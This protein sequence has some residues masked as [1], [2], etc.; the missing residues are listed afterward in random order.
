MTGVAGSVSIFLT[1]G[2]ASEGEQKHGLVLV[3]ASAKH[4]SE[5][6]SAN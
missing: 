2:G 5:N 6:L 1:D 3:K 4:Q